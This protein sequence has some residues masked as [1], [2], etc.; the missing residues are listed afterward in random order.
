MTKNVARNNCRPR[1]EIDGI[2]GDRHEIVVVGVGHVE[3][4]GGELGI[5]CKIDTF[6]S[7]R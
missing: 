6:V 3:F 5:V 1:R 2:T 4:T 7:A